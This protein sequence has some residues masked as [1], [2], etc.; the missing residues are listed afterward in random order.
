MRRHPESPSSRKMFLNLI[1]VRV[2]VLGHCLELHPNRH[3][4]RGTILPINPDNFRGEMPPYPL[5][6]FR[7]IFLHECTTVSVE[8]TDIELLTLYITQRVQ[9]SLAKKVLA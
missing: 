9:R 7:R 3:R 8:V 5:D 6:T 2:F 1:I 4:D